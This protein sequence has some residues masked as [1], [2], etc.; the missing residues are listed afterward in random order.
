MHYR[1]IWLG[2]GIPLG[3]LFCLVSFCIAPFFL[4][5][6]FYLTTG[7]AY[8]LADVAPRVTVEWN[9]IVTALICLCVIAFGMHYFLRWL[10][11]RVAGT[12]EAGTSLPWKRAGQC[13]CWQ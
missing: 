6:L 11:N 2:I 8:F 5:T 3:L 1:D 7:W 13:P 9:G 12:S 4:Q 10:R